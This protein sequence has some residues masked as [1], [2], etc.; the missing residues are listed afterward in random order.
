[1]NKRKKGGEG[2]GGEGKGEGKEEGKGRKK[3]TGLLE[4]LS[5]GTLVLLTNFQKG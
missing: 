5:V 3:K 4:D 2:K 1:M